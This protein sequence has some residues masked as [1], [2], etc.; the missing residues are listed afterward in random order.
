MKKAFFFVAFAMVITVAAGCRKTS[1]KV[2]DCLAESILT[3]VHTTVDGTNP[4]LVHI[5][6]KYSGSHRVTSVKWEYGDGKTATTSTL[7]SDY[8]YTTPGTYTIKAN[9]SISN[10]GGSCT[11]S[12][13]RQVTVN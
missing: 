3:S 1:E 4:K 6:A 7:T 8:T 13:T 10:N 2:I 11:V 5:E 12:P 9:V